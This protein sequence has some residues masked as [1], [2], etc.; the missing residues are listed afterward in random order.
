MLRCHHATVSKLAKRHGIGMKPTPTSRLFTDDDV[1]LLSMKIN[2]FHRF[3]HGNQCWKGRKS[4][5]RP[6]A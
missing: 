1:K 4:T 5:F 6:P 3:Q 2:N